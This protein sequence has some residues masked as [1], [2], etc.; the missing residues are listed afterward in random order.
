MKF[1]LLLGRQQSHLQKELQRLIKYRC[2]LIKIK[3]VL[4]FRNHIGHMLI[5]REVLGYLLL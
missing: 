1:Q 4:L 3:L 2:K 5:S